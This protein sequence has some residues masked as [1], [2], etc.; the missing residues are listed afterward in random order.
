MRRT[1]S[2]N[3]TTS[4]TPSTSPAYED[5]SDGCDAVPCCSNVYVSHS[6]DNA[7]AMPIRL[8]NETNTSAELQPICKPAFDVDLDSTANEPFAGK[9]PVLRSTFMICLPDTDDYDFA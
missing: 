8:P 2:P 5:T 7:P 9:T 3:I 1:P 6:T 4:F